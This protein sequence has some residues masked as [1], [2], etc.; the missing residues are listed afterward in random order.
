MWVDMKS[1]ADDV[2][3]CTLHKSRRTSRS[4]K[5]LRIKYNGQR[6]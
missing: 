6:H 2:M 3:H 5:T 4:S 1:H